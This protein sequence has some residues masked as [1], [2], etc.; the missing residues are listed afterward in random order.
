[1]SS[2]ITT[3]IGNE[4]MPS[5]LKDP[6]KKNSVTKIF[7]HFSQ[8]LF[9]KTKWSSTGYVNFSNGNTKGEQEFKG[10]TFDDVVLQIKAFLNTLD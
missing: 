5:I 9:D 8:S 1:M 7:V 4:K 6:F 10:E 3:K 2:E